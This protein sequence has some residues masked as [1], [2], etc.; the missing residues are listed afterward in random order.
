MEVIV[1][2]ALPDIL[3]I[4]DTDGTPYLRSKDAEMGRV[5]VTGVTELTVLY[6]PESGGGVRRLSV[7]LPFSASA[8][9]IDITPDSLI[10]AT[11]SLIAA[12]SRTV[13]PRK[14]VVKAEVACNATLFIPESIY[15]TAAKDRDD[16]YFK[17]E[18]RVM[19]LPAAV[20]EKTFIFTDELIFPSTAPAIGEIL[21]TSFRLLTEDTKAVGSKCVLKGS[22]ET[23]I[24]YTSREDGSLC[25]EHFSTPFS[26]I[27]DTD[28]VTEPGDFAVH[29]MLT[30]AYVNR[31][32]TSDGGGETLA[33]EIHAVAQCT[34]YAEMAANYL[35]DAY[36]T[37]Y[38]L[39]P[40]YSKCEFACFS[41]RE[42]AAETAL[43]SVPIAG[44][45]G[46]IH[47][48]T[49]RETS[50]ALRDEEGIVQYSAAMSVNVLY[51]DANGE[52]LSASKR[53]EWE[54]DL[55]TA[56]G[57]I[58][59]E[60]CQNGEVFTSSADGSIDLRV[61]VELTVTCVDQTTLDRLEG[62]E[63]DEEQKRDLADVPSITV[64]R[65]EETCDLWS[66][67]KSH[68]ST[69][70]LIREANGL[71]PD[72]QPAAGGILLIPRCR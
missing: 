19:N 16:I 10:T 49:V 37:K 62:L 9:G 50:A 13:N 14:I 61:P 35:S 40:A 29:L 58:S 30:G 12:D 55:E 24:L 17:S 71:E 43:V 36:S 25:R 8:E 66:L 21:K 31:G 46:A 28:A 47:H 26:Q 68:F 34:A 33:L 39:V 57:G 22:A 6:V 54:R 56:S 41:S 53:F 69:E 38:E 32:Y 15:N 42:R 70:G 51:S 3:R 2:D 52:L 44:T 4:V 59:V 11:V 7:N 67:A 27:I 63:Y 20:N 18:S 64:V 45:A 23:S 48:V 5:T 72:G 60:I 65:T 1:P